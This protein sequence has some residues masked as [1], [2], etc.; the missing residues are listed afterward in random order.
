VLRQLP[1]LIAPAATGGSWRAAASSNPAPAPPRPRQAASTHQ[2]ALSHL[3]PRMVL[4]RG[5]SITQAGDPR[6][7]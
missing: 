1:A 4:E 5:Y 2:R 6:R 7:T 3:G